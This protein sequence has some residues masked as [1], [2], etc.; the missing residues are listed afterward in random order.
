MLVAINKNETTGY[1]ISGLNTS[2]PVGTQTDY[3]TGLLGGVSI[4]VGSGSGGNNPVTTFTLPA[5]TVSVWQFTEGAASPQ[6]GSI[7]PTVG[8][9]GR[10]DR[11]RRQELRRVRR[12]GE[13]RHDDGDGQLVVGHANRGYYACRSPTATTTSR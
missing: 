8:T 1:S 3:L 12:H 5:H 4:T 6:I 11:H 9:T 13:I 2:L 10:E 7:G